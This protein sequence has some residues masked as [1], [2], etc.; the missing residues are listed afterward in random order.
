MA[1][2]DK[3][4]RLP[5]KVGGV[6]LPKQ[7]RKSAGVVA[8]L[9]QNPIAREVVSAALVAGAAALAKRRISGTPASANARKP[10]GEL[11]SLVAQGKDIGNMF[12]QG[13]SAFFGELLKPAEKAPAPS[14]PAS[15]KPA[16]SKGGVARSAARPAGAKPVAAKTAAAK[17]AAG[18][19]GAAKRTVRAK[20][21]P[22]PAS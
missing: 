17:P 7:F 5:K 1:K 12:A 16:A 22:K 21:R 4:A 11:D 20:P 19:S 8:E 14:D 6:K 2:K 9:A 13:V 10:G 15:A 18:K 3:A